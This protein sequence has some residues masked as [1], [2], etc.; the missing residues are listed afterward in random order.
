MKTEVN[1]KKRLTATGFTLLELLVVISIIGLLATFAVVAV[2]N[3]R[4]KARD[5]RR[6]HDMK[7]ITKAL[8]MYNDDFKEYP[9]ENIDPNHMC[10]LF[11][12]G[13][14]TKGPYFDSWAI[15][16]WYSGSGN[17]FEC[18][19]NGECFW[20]EDL[21]ANLKKYI[22][23]MPVDPLQAKEGSYN[24]MILGPC[25]E[26]NSY[27]RDINKNKVIPPCYVPGIQGKYIA[28]FLTE[29]ETELGPAGEKVYNENGCLEY[30]GCTCPGGDIVCGNE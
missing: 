27:C 24:F 19:N 7:Q 22:P 6:L 4:V 13:E 3:A 5:T 1:Q 9:C 12:G 26:A 23:M 20:R 30:I 25:H 16:V 8:E 15:E 14:S 28:H 2:Q 29:R 17:W 21:I 11:I 10:A 18:L